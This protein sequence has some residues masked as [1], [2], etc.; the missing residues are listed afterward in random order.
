MTVKGKDLL[1]FDSSGY[2]GDIVLN[3]G[4]LTTEHSEFLKCDGGIYKRSDY[5]QIEKLFGHVGIAPFTGV[6]IEQASFKF[7]QAAGVGYIR[8][9]TAQ[10]GDD[11][12]AIVLTPYNSSGS[13]WVNTIVSHDGGVTWTS[14][15]KERYGLYTQYSVYKV[16]YKKGT[17]YIAYR[18][19]STSR[20]TDDVYILMYKDDGS[21]WQNQRVNHASNKSSSYAPGFF[22]RNG[23]LYL[24]HYN[25]DSYHL[26]YRSITDTQGIGSGWTEI[27]ITST[28]SNK[29]IYIKETNQIIIGYLYSGTAALVN[30]DNTL[31]TFTCTGLTQS[32]RFDTSRMFYKNNEYVCIYP[33][34][35]NTESWIFRSK[36]LINWTEEL[37]PSPIYGDTETSSYYYYFDT[38]G[39]A[40]LFADSNNLYLQYRD[41]KRYYKLGKNA[42]KGFGYIGRVKFDEKTNEPYLLAAV[43]ISTSDTEITCRIVKCYMYEILKY[44]NLPKM[45]QLSKITGSG[46]TEYPCIRT[47]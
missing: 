11:A 19:I 27:D 20:G 4:D 33:Y 28:S 26:I 38:V 2:P 25:G 34:T 5:P 13:A 6:E 42:Y 35:T 22:E 21:V 40:S 24:W 43:Q 3:Y 44:F 9:L 39:D 31:T 29:C 14:I 16:V 12:V 46:S 23:Y 37:I 15:K 47:E 41:S 32:G 18:P 1:E 36:D 45:N 17:I 10:D 8:G 7:S 30:E